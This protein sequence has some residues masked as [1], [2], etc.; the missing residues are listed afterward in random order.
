M[1]FVL[2]GHRTVVVTVT[3]NGRGMV[4]EILRD[5]THEWGECTVSHVISPGKPFAFMPN[6]HDLQVVTPR[7]VKEFSDPAHARA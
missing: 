5:S 3:G 1:S 4:R 2:K 6:G 7:E